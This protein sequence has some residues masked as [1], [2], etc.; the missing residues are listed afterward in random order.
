MNVTDAALDIRQTVFIAQFNRKL[1]DE[2][3]LIFFKGS[4]DRPAQIAL[5][6]APRQRIDRH[7]TL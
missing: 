7:D 4:F 5:C 6:H 3:V 1:F 2:P